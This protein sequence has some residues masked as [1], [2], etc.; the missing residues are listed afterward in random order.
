MTMLPGV[1][2]ICLY[3]LFS[4]FLQSERK[5]FV[6]SASPLIYNLIFLVAIWWVK[7]W[8]SADAMQGLA[9]GVVAAFL[10]QWLMVIPGTMKLLKPYLSWK[11]WLSPKLFSPQFIQ[12]VKGIIYTVI[13]V[14]AVQINT[15]IDTLFAHAASLS[16]PAYLN[17][18]IRLHHLPLSLFG[19]ALA[20][21]LL[22]PLSR[23]M[24]GGKIAEYL[25][26]L[27]FALSR[28]FT[29]IF[30]CS[31]AVL[32]LGASAVNLVYGHGLFDFQATVQVTICLWAY[33][34]GLM[35]AV[36]VLLLAPAFYA[37]KDFKTPLK[38]SLLSVALSLFL[39][40][41]LVFWLG[42]GAASIALATSVAAFANYKFLSRKLSNAI[43]PIF[44]QESRNACM[45]VMVCSLL[46]G[47]STLAVGHYF[48]NDP[49]VNMLLHGKEVAFP[50]AL[51]H[52]CFQFL[53]LSVAFGG[54]LFFYAWIVKADSILR[55]RKQFL[56]DQS[57]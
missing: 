22:P 3:A 30:P 5:Y 11:E 19:I 18:A 27:H 37:K 9:L 16:G 53:S 6:S 48:L 34:I 39:N 21:A 57:I 26:L 32:V 38:A 28:S 17:F 29:L 36:L 51:L 55:I 41:I 56:P 23:A 49:T 10:C 8:I 47:A 46:A 54:L 33:G 42:L 20:S 2:F 52:Q 1:L 24:Q 4:A 12:M 13:G 14:G 7:D 40:A 44:D 31:V 43:G 15:A 25:K 50:R 35:P 45:K